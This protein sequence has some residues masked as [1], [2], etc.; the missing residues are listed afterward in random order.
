MLRS[1][2]GN[3]VPM[4]GLA[5][6]SCGLIGGLQHQVLFEGYIER[7]LASDDEVLLHFPILHSIVEHMA[8]S[9]WMK[10]SGNPTKP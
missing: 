4:G 5:F 8:A 2:T 10:S 7:L 9:L 3:I 1:I 6:T